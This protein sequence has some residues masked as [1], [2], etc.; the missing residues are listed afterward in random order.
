MYATRQSRT[1]KR[2][3]EAEEVCSETLP[4]VRGALLAEEAAARRI[5]RWMRRKLFQRRVEA[6]WVSKRRFDRALNERE[7]FFGTALRDIEHPFL[8]YIK[9]G[10]FYV[11]ETLLL[12]KAISD[13]GRARNPYTNVA[14]T[15]HELRRLDVAASRLG[16]GVCLRKKLPFLE[17]AAGRIAQHEA[18]VRGLEDDAL[19]AGDVLFQSADATHEYVFNSPWRGLAQHYD[20]DT[21]S[22]DTDG[23][24]TAGTA[25]IATAT[26]RI[27]TEYTSRDAYIGL[28]VLRC[29]DCAQRMPPFLVPCT[30]GVATRGAK[31]APTCCIV[32]SLH[33]W[34][35]D[36]FT[37]LVQLYQAGGAE[38]HAY[39]WQ[40]L[41]REWAATKA[42]AQRQDV[43]LRD[44]VCAF[45]DPMFT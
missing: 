37:V 16:F 24:R 7:V 4:C 12:A 29:A 18:L 3:R 9:G 45:L 26:S 35:Q 28:A 34:L 2:A 14:L 15:R 33:T 40:R 27:T 32:R 8:L 21:E 43:V 44:V 39:A 38:R 31:R 10:G 30:L 41:K 6:R 22:Y 11:F 42:R 23:P 5:Q 17:V 1:R 19:A 25:G 20:S 13:V 36:L